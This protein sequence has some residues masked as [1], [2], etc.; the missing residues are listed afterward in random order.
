MRHVVLTVAASV[1]GAGDLAWAES[2]PSAPWAMVPSSPNPSTMTASVS[3]TVPSREE[4]SDTV[5]LRN[6]GEVR[7]IAIDVRVGQTVTMRTP[8]G[9]LRVIAWGDIAS[10]SGP[11]FRH[12]LPGAP[13]A[14][15]SAP[16]GDLE[17]L[18]ALR[19]RDPMTYL[20]QRPGTVPVRVESDGDPLEVS[21]PLSESFVPRGAGFFAGTSMMAPGVQSDGVVT[22]SPRGGFLRVCTTPCTLYFYPG[23]Q[24]LRL[25][26]AG[27]RES[28]ELVEV[29]PRGARV[30]FHAASSS[31]YMVGQGFL[32]AGASLMVVGVLF[33]TAGA[34]CSPTALCDM[35]APLFFLVSGALAVGVGVPLVVLNQTGPVEI[36]TDERRVRG[37]SATAARVGFGPVPGGALGTLG[38][39][40]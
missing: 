9:E 2:A 23:V 20:H 36:P 32:W 30:R 1:L 31:Q 7:G 21:V 3:M 8:S 5:A 25:G 24:P 16:V 18:V 28:D 15:P 35:T 14:P 22:S 27:Y 6:G 17:E 40:F 37:G 12:V 19:A 26:G 38:L 4:P 10:A 33:V 11:A 29:T 39:V 34:R 13:P